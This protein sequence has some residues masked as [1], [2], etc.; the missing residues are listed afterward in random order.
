MYRIL[1]VD[2]E[3]L[4]LE[5]L[6]Q[7]LPSFFSY[8]E[9]ELLQA[10]NGVEAM[11]CI[12]EAEIDILITDI[13]MPEVDG[14]NLSEFVYRK[15]PNTFII[16]LS[17]YEEF[18]YA[19]K[20]IQLC[21]SEYLLK[22]IVPEELKEAIQRLLP[23]IERRREEQRAYDSILSGNRNSAL[24]ALECLAN[25]THSKRA[26]SSKV[27]SV[28]RKYIDTHY[29]KQISLSHVAEKAGVTQS[30]FSN[31]FHKEIGES[32][33]RYLTRIRM[34]KAARLLRETSCK[35]Y[36]VASEVGYV[37][38]KHFAQ[39]FKQWHG[40]SPHQYRNTYS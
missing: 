34:Q 30:Y 22:P 6:S 11:I 23:A 17:G 18:S 26:K 36:E 25:Q 13:R 2:D 14:I 33:S 15:Y 28:G 12:Q 37:S 1:I 4:T 3:P 7:L 5:Y 40:I 24:D 16:F 9:M 19:H 20:A 27:V 38:V 21:V 8:E 39:K 32:Y 31:I 10:E 29:K 35:V